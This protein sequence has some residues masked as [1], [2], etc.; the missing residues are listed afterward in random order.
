MPGVHVQVV[1]VQGK[2]FASPWMKESLPAIL[3]AWQSGQAQ[4]L[5]VAETVFGFNNPAG[6]AAVTFPASAD[7]LPVFYNYHPTAT[8]GGYNN[9]PVISGGVYPPAKKVQNAPT[10]F[11]PPLLCKS[12]HQDRLG[13]NIGENEKRPVFLSCRALKAS[14]G[15][16]VTAWYSTYAYAKRKT[17]TQPTAFDFS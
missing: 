4:G 7:M 2:A 6:R 12:F 1:V 3:E 13:T 9:P 11:E 8:R 15:R 17:Q 14:C 16:L 5:A 10:P